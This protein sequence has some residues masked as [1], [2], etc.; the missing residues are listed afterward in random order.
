MWQLHS[1]EGKAERLY[2]YRVCTR[3][4][5][6][7]LDTWC[8]VLLMRIVRCVGVPFDEVATAVASVDALANVK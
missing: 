1:Y 5:D 6:N 4:K 7:D 8:D 3:K 2:A